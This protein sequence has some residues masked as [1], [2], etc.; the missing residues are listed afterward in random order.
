[1]GGD[2]RTGTAVVLFVD[3]VGSTAARSELGD[4]VADR[5]RKL[6][7]QAIEGGVARAG[8][9]IVKWLGDGAV[10][11]FD[12][13][14]AGIDAAL[15]MQRRITAANRA[16][17][18]RP[19]ALRVGLSAGDVAW[20]AN[21]VFGTPVVEAARLEAASEPGAVW[22]SDVVRLLAG[23]RTD[24]E[25]TDV[26]E[27]ELK[28][29]QQPLR[30]WSVHRPL[31]A[32][33]PPL[34]VRMQA[35]ET[36]PF[37]GR[38][39]ALAQLRSS[40]ERANDHGVQI[41]FVSGEPGA[42]KSRLLREFARTVHA[43]GVTVA[44]GRC[45]E[46]VGTPLWPFTQLYREIT[47]WDDERA[48][49]LGD[50]P[51]V[52]RELLGGGDRPTELVDADLVHLYEAVLSWFEDVASVGPLAIV[53][54]DLQWA[55]A[56]TV[57]LLR[58]VMRA[59]STAPV[60]FAINHR[61]DADLSA[62]VQHLRRD[63][64]RHESASDIDLRGLAA[65]DLV[66][67]LPATSGDERARL[68]E[69]TGGNPF[70]ISAIGDVS[71]PD[72][73]ALSTSVHDVVATRLD[74]LDRDALRIADL[75]A[76]M[77]GELDL[78]VL[79]ACDEGN[80]RTV[81]AALDNLVQRGLV[82][83]VPGA[84]TRYRFAH[85]IARDTLYRR[86]PSTQVHRHHEQ[87]ARAIEARYAGQLDDHLYRVVFHYPRAAPARGLERTIEYGL[88]A[89][90]RALDRAA[91]AEALQ[92]FEA[93]QGAID[94]SPTSVAVRQRADVELALGMA[95]RR[96]RKP[97]ARDTLLS[98]AQLAAEHGIDE[99][100]VRA[101]S[102]N[103][104]PWA[105]VVHD[106]DRERSYVLALS[107]VD[108]D[109]DATRSWLLASRSAERYLALDSAAS[110]RLSDEAL[111]RARRS[112]DVDALN[113]VVHYRHMTQTRPGTAQER[114]DLAHELR[115]AH[116]QSGR[117]S[118]PPIDWVLQAYG[119]ATELGDLDTARSLVDELTSAALRIRDVNL[120]YH[121]RLLEAA[122]AAI[123]G[124]ALEAL[125]L[126]DEMLAVGT[127]AQQPTAALWWLGVSFNP[128]IITDR[129]DQIVPMFEQ[130]MASDPGTDP[131]RRD[132]LGR[133]RAGYTLVLAETGQLDE[134]AAALAP[135]VANDFADVPYDRD[136]FTVLTRY[137]VIVFDLGDRHA[138]ERLYRQLE[139][140]GD[141][142]AGN[143]TGWMGRIDHHLGLLADVLGRADEA[144]HRLTVA[145]EFHRHIGASAAYASSLLALGEVAERN[146][147]RVEAQR[148][149]TQAERL[150]SASGFNRITHRIE[151]ITAA[152]HH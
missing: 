82:V 36:L 72:M 3:Q 50:A 98:V 51:D 70:F 77:G 65:D 136:W 87:I 16:G 127:R 114:L 147:R 93:V 138:A 43:E 139:P 130:I 85:A 61:N 46:G 107:T 125:A 32:S 1:M 132:L 96:L 79:A 83:E 73:L 108:P 145:A 53:I 20:E 47:A 59:E 33:V 19:M 118:A 67:V 42:G 95:Q 48:T 78:G 45:D 88:E 11:T 37:G 17:A 124:R 64:A 2:A 101:A 112:G 142:C 122:M 8:G 92:Y 34:P 86:I 97:E 121:A 119:A 62:F 74:G 128:A 4:G 100:V 144:T 39:V 44:S 60:L 49:R 7:E 152:W 113:H 131:I 56:T 94:D 133:V 24:A 55:D 105:T 103:T 137:A 135:F 110:D 35:V 76:V 80:E 58:F 71:D 89:G 120:A 28:G 52:L 63:G 115:D 30:T 149:F 99:V 151:R 91:Y 5:V 126:A 18:P 54:D 40:L 148:W 90:H 104:V 123:E 143:T 102:T 150:A 146:G 15:E 141:L 109:D 13:A 38:D 81:D 25:F 68:I 57:A 10:A 75:A 6:Y 41:V 29:L 23:S 69:I 117:R 129:T 21:D 26:G 116:A 12:S 134:A 106:P 9:T 31:D 14:T 111:E 66:E 140:F 22:C 27:L 84:V